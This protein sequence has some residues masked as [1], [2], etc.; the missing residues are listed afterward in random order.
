[1]ANHQSRLYSALRGIAIAC[2]L[3]PLFSLAM[4]AYANEADPIRLG[5][6][7]L[8]VIAISPDGSRLAVGTTIGVYF[9]NA[10]TFTPEGFWPTPYETEY[11]RWSP[12]SDVLAII[13]DYTQVDFWSVANGQQLWSSRVCDKCTIEFS[14]DGATISATPDWKTAY[15]YDVLTGQQ[16][17][18]EPVVPGHFWPRLG[19]MQSISPDRRWLVDGYYT[20]EVF[21]YDLAQPHDYP[22][23]SLEKHATGGGWYYRSFAWSPDSSILYSAMGNTVIAWDMQSHQQLRILDGFSPPVSNLVWSNDGHSIL[24]EEGDYLVEVDVATRLPV[25]AGL[26]ARSNDITN[27]AL[28]PTSSLLAVTDYYGVTLYDYTT[29]KQTRRILI[30]RT[31]ELVAFTP[32]GA[33]M[34]TAGRGPFVNIWQTTTGKPIADVLCSKYSHSIEAITFKA[35]GQTLFIYGSD[36]KRCEWNLGTNILTVSD[37]SGVCSCIAAVSLGA[38]QLAIDTDKGVEIIDLINNSV[39]QPLE[40]ST[41]GSWLDSYIFNP[42]SSRLAQVKPLQ[43]EVIIWDAQSG[44]FLEEYHDH[45]SYTSD[46]AFS[47]DGRLFATSSSDGTIVIRETP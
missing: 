31:I 45:N 12:R 18:T 33:Y 10:N 39:T 37:V 32:D 27:I 5:L 4:S 7:R 41:Q 38:A 21:V 46:L 30:G 26:L 8:T 23:F 24:A 20:G 14:E 19:W 1:M 42:A 6:G 3:A 13:H 9:Y 36:G 11:L 43:A 29:F 16:L 40:N 15:T 22:S 28:D 17:K 44:Q 34:A 47:P 35:D 2:L 25:R